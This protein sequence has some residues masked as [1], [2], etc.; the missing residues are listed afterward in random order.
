MSASIYNINKWYLI[1]NFAIF[2]SQKIFYFEIFEQFSFPV[3]PNS[4]HL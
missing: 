1:R 3:T 4:D 2:E